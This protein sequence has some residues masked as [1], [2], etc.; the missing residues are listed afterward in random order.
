MCPY[1]FTR[2][3]YFLIWNTVV[4]NC[5]EELPKKTCRPTVGQLSADSWPTGYRQVTDS[6]PTANQQVTDRLRKKKNCGKN[7]QLTLT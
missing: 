1:H 7:E 4:G 3:T 2:P 6:L 5:E